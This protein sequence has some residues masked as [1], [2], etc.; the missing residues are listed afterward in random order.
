[1]QVNGVGLLPQPTE[2]PS[3]PDF[4]RNYKKPLKTAHSVPLIDG[5]SL[6]GVSFSPLLSCTSGAQGDISHAGKVTEK[7]VKDTQHKLKVRSHHNSVTACPRLPELDRI[8]S[9][10]EKIQGRDQEA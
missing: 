6:S 10:A 1:M 5:G 3:G 9:E 7:K 2:L 4:L 8:R